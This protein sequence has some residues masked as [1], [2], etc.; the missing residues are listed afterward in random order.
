[1]PK[2]KVLLSTFREAVHQQRAL[3]V[4][5][6]GL[7][8]E[9]CSRPTPDQL[10]SRL[11][12]FDVL[13]TERLGVVNAVAIEGAPHL[14][15]IQRLGRMTHDIDLEAAQRAGIPVCNWPLRSCAMVAEHVVMQ[16]LGL[17]KRSRECE[18]VLRRPGEG[19]L[20]PRKCDGNYFAINWT[21]RQNIRPIAG[22]TVGIMGFGE[23]GSELAMRLRP[24]DCRILYNKRT[25]L[26]AQV[27]EQFGMRYAD[28]R[29]IRAE[30]DFLCLLLPHIASP[31]PAIG[32]DFIT[33]MKDGACL[34]SAGSSSTLNEKD[35]A[36]AYRQGKLSGV[37]TDGWAW[38]PLLPDNPLLGLA[39]NP[40][41]N[42]VFTPHT[43]G[44]SLT[45]ADIAS[46]RRQ[47]WHNVENLLRGEPLVNRII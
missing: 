44:G 15:L 25:R 43:A 9:V 19:D 10:A 20:P 35:V 39:D 13:V 38:E 30:S 45:A 33:G 28:W 2:L 6:A 31:E 8:I 21:R 34:I 42:V 24:F 4:A 46:N 11:P 22:S 18:A 40:Q 41:A 17:A 16:L 3:E 27:E 32:R 12:D 14:R 1:M 23:V 47:E 37:A 36:E 5:P 7:D 29:S 26:P